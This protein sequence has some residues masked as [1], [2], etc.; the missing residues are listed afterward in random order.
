MVLVDIAGED[1]VTRSIIRKLIQVVC[2]GTISVGM[3][4]PFRGSQVKRETPR[5]NAL[6][7]QVPVVLLADLDAEPCPVTSRQLWLEGG[8]IHPGFL[9]RF[10][11]DEA[12]SWLLA[13]RE[14][15]AAY[16]HISPER[17]PLPSPESRLRPN[18][19]EIRPPMKSSLFLMRELAANSP[20]SNLRNQLMPRHGA[21][22]GPAYNMALMPFIQSEWNPFAAEANSSSLARMI[23]ALKKWGAYVT[24]I[25]TP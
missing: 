9:F 21:S 17:I 23:R 25:N 24:G 20:L 7:V 4:R 12:E 16:L 19:L 22:K 5:L 10:A 1:E 6:A 3:E 8:E 13:D 11:R 2:P 15:L 14:G 18:E